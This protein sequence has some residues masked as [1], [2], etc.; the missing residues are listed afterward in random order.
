MSDRLTRW[1]GRDENGD[2][3]VMVDR[4]SPFHAA[5]QAVLRKLARYEDAEEKENGKNRL[6]E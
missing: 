6:L 4:S 3:A 5:F 1:E 2:R